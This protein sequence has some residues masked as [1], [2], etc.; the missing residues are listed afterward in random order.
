MNAATRQPRCDARWWRLLEKVLFGRVA[1]V[2]AAVSSVLFVLG[3]LNITVGG[4][5]PIEVKPATDGNGVLVQ[6]GKVQVRSGEEQLVYYPVRYAS[7]PNLE[8]DDSICLCS[9]VEQSETCFRVRF[10]E[11]VWSSHELSWKARGVPGPSPAAAPAP[12]ADA[13]P[14]APALPAA[15]VPVSTSSSQR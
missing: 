15:P 12:V 13:S 2:V 7:P 9:L 5:T 10:K 4:S 14:P 1:T 3:C 6:E 11:G 8:L